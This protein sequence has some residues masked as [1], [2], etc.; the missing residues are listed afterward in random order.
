MLGTIGLSAAGQSEIWLF[1]I[2]HP[3]TLIGCNWQQDKRSL[4][5]QA[6]NI[7][8]LKLKK[9]EREREFDFDWLSRLTDL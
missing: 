3:H 7:Q 6:L 4:K 1:E 8:I 2:A 5:S 9:R